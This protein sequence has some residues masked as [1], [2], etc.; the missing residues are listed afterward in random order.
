VKTF[1]IGEKIDF[2][3]YKQR[4]TSSVLKTHSVKNLAFRTHQ[5]QFINIRQNEIVS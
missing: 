5:Q 3:K 2:N 4:P 1:S